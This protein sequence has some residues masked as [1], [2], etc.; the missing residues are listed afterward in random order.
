M[1]QKSSTY[2]V[3]TVFFTKPTKTHYLM[4]IS[5]S[6]SIAHTVVKNNLNILVKEEII[7]ESEEKKGSRIFPIYKANI[8]NK[9][10]RRQK[11]LHNL[12]TILESGLIEF[13]E[14]RLT[15]NAIVLFGSYQKGEDIEDSDIDIF[16]ECKEEKI[17]IRKFENKLQRRI[18]LHFKENFRAFPKELK[19]NIINGIVLHGFLEGYK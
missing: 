17:S 15:P 13:I 9:N 18:Q 16:L 1:L 2:K 11:R 14:Q 19:N 12:T 8:N 4:E 3:L 5:R 6:I 7:T 10:Y